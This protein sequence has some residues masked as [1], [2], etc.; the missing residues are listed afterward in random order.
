MGRP[1]RLLLLVV[2]AAVALVSGSVSVGLESDA[3]GFVGTAAIKDPPAAA[4]GAAAHPSTASPAFP[5]EEYQPN[6][7]EAAA[8]FPEVTVV[9]AESL[10]AGDIS[11]Q[12]VF[13][14]TAADLAAVAA[15]MAGPVRR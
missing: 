14:P 1:A 10:L 5:P 4:P 7:P 15:Q 2:L 6:N 13:Q 12:S 9:S 11:A 3:A 8:A